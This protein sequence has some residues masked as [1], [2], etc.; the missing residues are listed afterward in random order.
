MINLSNLKKRGP[1][2][3]VQVG[4]RVDQETK[5]WL[6][7]FCEINNISISSFVAELIKDFK[8]GQE[9]A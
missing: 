8:R 1:A 7:K 5:D 2:N 6:D 4:V 3:V 9:H